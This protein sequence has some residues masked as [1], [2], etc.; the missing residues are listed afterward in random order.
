MMRSPTKE[1]VFQAIE[2]YKRNGSEYQFDPFKERTI[3]DDAVVL[4]DGRVIAYGMVKL[5]AE[6]VLV[7]DK[8]A[9]RIEKAKALKSLMGLALDVTKNK[10]ISELYT[11]ADDGKFSNLL[12]EQFDFQ[13]IISTPLVRVLE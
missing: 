6:A 13:K 1:D 5:F 8:D 11:F 2:L 4:K 9:G 3:L 7:L 12:I 10:G